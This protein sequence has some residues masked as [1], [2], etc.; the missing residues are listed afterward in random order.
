MAL[1]VSPAEMAAASSSS[2]PERQIRIA[3]R[4]QAAAL[5]DGK[6]FEVTLDKTRARI[7][8]VLTPADPQMILLVLDMVGDLGAIEPAKDALVA[9]I[10]KLPPA[11]YQIKTEEI[12]R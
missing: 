9:E 11:V 4:A 5:V 10:E 6:S 12:V 3:V 2:G 1:F 7:A 8:H